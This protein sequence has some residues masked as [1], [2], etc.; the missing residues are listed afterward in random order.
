MNV[1]SLA[2]L[3]MYTFFTTL[4]TLTTLSPIGPAPLSSLS[5][6]HFCHW[7]DPYG[8]FGH[9]LTYSWISNKEKVETETQGRFLI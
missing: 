9:S 4:Y 6:P 7:P 3:F 5:A 8:A 1:T 2:L